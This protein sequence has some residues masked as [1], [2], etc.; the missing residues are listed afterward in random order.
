VGRGEHSRAFHLA[1]ERF[2]FEIQKGVPEGHVV[3]EF[4]AGEDQPRPDPQVVTDLACSL[5]AT[6]QPGR[7]GHAGTAGYGDRTAVGAGAHA[8]G[9]IAAHLLRYQ[10]LANR[11]LFLV[12]AKR[13]AD[14]HH[15]A[16]VHF[17]YGRD[18]RRERST[19]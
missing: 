15:G 7:S 6:Q 5:E 17:I 12:N 19:R 18:D 10:D 2:R 4:L 1:T 13:D 14:H 16:R 9:F 11:L 8:L 3:H